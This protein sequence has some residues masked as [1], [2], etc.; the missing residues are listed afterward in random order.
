MTVFWSVMQNFHSIKHN[1]TG[2]L[3]TM[4]WVS[5]DLI[6]SRVEPFPLCSWFWSNWTL[7]KKDGD[8]EISEYESTAGKLRSFLDRQLLPLSSKFQK[9]IRNQHSYKSGSALCH[10]CNQSKLN[11][12]ERWSGITFTSLDA[13]FIVFVVVVVVVV[14]SRSQLWTI[15]VGKRNMRHSNSKCSF[16]S[17]CRAALV[18]FISI[19]IFPTC[20]GGAHKNNFVW[21]SNFSVL[22]C[23]SSQPSRAQPCLREGNGSDGWQ[24]HPGCCGSEP[25]SYLEIGSRYSRWCSLSSTTTLTFSALCVG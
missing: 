7:Q 4:S 8:L 21:M 19:H 5:G 1:F 25:T 10:E 14:S 22:W 17:F 18:H 2:K 13:S 6:I 23:S 16:N 11:S 15:A 12:T 9:Y 24:H 3:S 20:W